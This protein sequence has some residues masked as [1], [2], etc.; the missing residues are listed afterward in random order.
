MNRD[1][2]YYKFINSETGNTI[3]FLS[4]PKDEPNTWERLEKARE[5]LACE[6]GIYVGNIY[7]SRS[8]EQDFDE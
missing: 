1:L 5:K 8:T 7:Y 6:K 2:R 4:F 3:Y